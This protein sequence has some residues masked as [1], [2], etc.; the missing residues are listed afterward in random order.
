MLGKGHGGLFLQGSCK[1]IKKKAK[2]KEER[3]QIKF[4][5]LRFERYVEER[6]WWL[7]QSPDKGR[8]K[9]KFKSKEVSDEVY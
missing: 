7:T 4:I 9:G 6:P 5:D 8:K 2:G 1:G 3:D